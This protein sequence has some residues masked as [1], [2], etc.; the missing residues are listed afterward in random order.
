MCLAGNALIIKY[1]PAEVHF[2]VEELQKQWASRRMEV[3][4][5]HYEVMSSPRAREKFL[6][7]W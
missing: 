4:D 2:T 6:T 1:G 5:A 7:T 3:R